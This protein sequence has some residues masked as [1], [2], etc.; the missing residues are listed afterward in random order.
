MMD[1]LVGPVAKNIRC[2]PSVKGEK[3]KRLHV[4]AN[5]LRQT[6]LLGPLGPPI[7]PKRSKQMA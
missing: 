2:V 3:E 1:L 4:L 6:L 7:G 5:E